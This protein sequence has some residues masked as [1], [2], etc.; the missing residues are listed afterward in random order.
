MVKDLEI[1]SLYQRIFINSFCSLTR[2]V[3]STETSITFS[4]VAGK[5][6]VTYQENLAAKSVDQFFKE[7][8]FRF[9]FRE[10]Y[11]PK[12]KTFVEPPARAQ[13]MGIVGKVCIKVFF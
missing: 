9:Y 12:E 13:T 6:F 5:C 10:A 11:D 3:L 7:G 2:L 8:P 1:K 4:D